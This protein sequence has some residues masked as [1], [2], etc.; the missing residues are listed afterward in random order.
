[1]GEFSP[2]E[3]PLSGV[4]LFRPRV[5][6]DSRGFFL[7]SWSERDFKRLLPGVSFVQEN[8]S[9]SRRGVLRGLHFQN[10]FPQGKLIRVVRG[11]VFDVVVD[12]RRDSPTFGKWWS[13]ELSEEN[14]LMLYV[15]PGF[16]HGFFVLSEW[17]DV[18]YKVT[19]YYHPECEGGIFWADEA[20]G[21]PWPLEEA[22][23]KEPLLSEK[24]KRWPRF[25]EWVKCGFS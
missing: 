14:F 11:R 5:F 1:M 12:L 16:A 21:I 10:P 15:P 9:R 8:H 6:T 24:D 19:E 20:L 13:V 2:E 17:A 3:A 22:G 23:V 7:E 25:T 18:L 4:V